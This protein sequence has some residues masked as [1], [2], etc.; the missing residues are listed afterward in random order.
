QV[1]NV[2]K[3]FFLAGSLLTLEAWLRRTKLENKPENSLI[4]NFSQCFLENAQVYYA[5]GPMTMALDDMRPE[6]QTYQRLIYKLARWHFVRRDKKFVEKLAEKSKIM[7]A[8]SSFCASMYRRWG[9]EA[10]KVIYPPLDCAVFK[11][12]NST[13]TSDYVLTYAGKETKY[14]VLK[15]IAESGVKVKVFGSKVSC[16]KSLLQQSNIEFLGKI[17]DEELV[18]AYSNALFTIFSFTHEPFGYIP[19]ESMACGTPVL[20]Y[21]RQGPAESVID[22]ETGWLVETDE[23]I[24]ST[25][26]ELWRKGYPSNIRESCRKRAMLFDVETISKEWLEVIEEFVS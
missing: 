23:Q 13:P 20:T 26:A 8:N 15:R 4:V 1:W 17:T 7:I 2:N 25:A 3:R 21:N 9:V 11:P 22:G 12:S 5:Q 10:K 6:M 16:P 14:S 19:V 24:I 18:N